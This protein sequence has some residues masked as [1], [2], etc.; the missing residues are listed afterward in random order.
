MRNLLLTVAIVMLASFTATDKKELKIC[1]S[2]FTGTNNCANA[3]MTVTQTS[4]SGVNYFTTTLRPGDV[5]YFLGHLDF[6]LSTFDVTIGRRGTGPGCVKLYNQNGNLIDAQP[7][8]ASTSVVTLTGTINCGTSY[9]I[10]IDDN[11]C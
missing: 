11:P 9:L 7:W 2:G 3:T 10:V 6:G 4:S 5:N 1:A 8:S